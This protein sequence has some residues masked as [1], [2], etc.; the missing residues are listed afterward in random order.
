[1]LGALGFG[2]AVCALNNVFN[3]EVLEDGAYG[4]LF[5]KARGH[6]E[7]LIQTIEDQPGRLDALREKGPERIAA[8]YTWEKI[9]AQ[10]EAL[11]ERL[12]KTP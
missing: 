8:T 7:R 2:A 11:F 1:M 3:R 9:T 6:L 12:V 10:Y 4:L 5:D